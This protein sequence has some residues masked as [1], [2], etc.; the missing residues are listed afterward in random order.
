M[1]LLA[2]SE[3]G[4]PASVKLMTTPDGYP[5]TILR[6]AGTINPGTHEFKVPID[7]SVESVVFS[8]AV[9]CLQT[10]DVIRPSGEI[11]SGDGVTD[12]GNFIANRMV[13][14]NRPAAGVWT[15]RV[16]GSGLAGVVVKARSALQ[17]RVEFVPPGGSQPSPGP[18]AGVENTVLI[19]IGGHPSRVEAAIVNG[20]S[21]EIAA[22]ALTAVEDGVFTARFT[23]GA[24]PF[25]VM[26]RGT[27]ASG[28][29]FQRVQAA[30]HQ[31]R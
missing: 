5:Q 12:L 14:V 21:K 17:T 23:P 25:R 11:A 1:L 3:M 24:D 13:I 9:Q 18:F 16:G 22:L 28:A 26:I 27:D 15:I 2:P 4:D 19:S 29:P 8:I 10:A 30:L 31:A 7:P 20:A 6:S